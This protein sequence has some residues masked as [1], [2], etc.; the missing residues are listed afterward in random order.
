MPC[1][2]PGAGPL[3]DLT[4]LR[5][6]VGFGARMLIGQAM[7]ASGAPVTEDE[8]CRR[9]VDIFIAHYHRPYRRWDAA[10][11]GGDAKPWRR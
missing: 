9:L 6:M 3:L 11:S 8:T 5:H 10:V 1:W 4:H 2:R 7:E